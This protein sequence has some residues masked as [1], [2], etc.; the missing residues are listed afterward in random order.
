MAIG[1]SDTEE[2]AAYLLFGKEHEAAHYCGVERPLELQTGM[3][4]LPP[5]HPG[6][7]CLQ[8]RQAKEDVIINVK[9]TCWEH[10][11]SVNGY[12]THL[13]G[14]AGFA[15]APQRGFYMYRET[16]ISFYLDNAFVF[17]GEFHQPE[18]ISAIVASKSLG[19]INERRANLSFVQTTLEGLRQNSIAP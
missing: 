15:P 14:K 13:Y 9:R 4:I 2:G 8:R 1:S 5:N 18:G 6:I 12:A 16:R 10:G 17:H 19:F 7:P 3:P 11:A